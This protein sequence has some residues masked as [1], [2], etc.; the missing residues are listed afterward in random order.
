MA[1]F[2]GELLDELY[3]ATEGVVKTHGSD[4]LKKA[5]EKIGYATGYAKSLAKEHPVLATVAFLTVAGPLIA[6]QP[7]LARG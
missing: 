7:V 1:N 3:E 4:G 6:L 5:L 2:Y